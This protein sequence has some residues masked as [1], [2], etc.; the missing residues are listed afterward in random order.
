MVCFVWRTFQSYWTTTVSFFI[1]R[2]F[3]YH[4]LFNNTEC[5]CDSL[6]SDRG[7]HSTVLRSPYSNGFLFAGTI[8]ILS[9]HLQGSL[10]LIQQYNLFRA[11]CSLYPLVYQ[12]TL[13][14][15]LSDN[16][17]LTVCSTYKT[18][19]WCTMRLLYTSLGSSYNVVVKQCSQRLTWVIRKLHDEGWDVVW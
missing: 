13:L 10:D 9:H 3:L 19:C 16:G 1:Y 15:K 2:H 12:H 6:K 4:V 8:I 18:A 7:S 11:L 14:T 17:C 5:V